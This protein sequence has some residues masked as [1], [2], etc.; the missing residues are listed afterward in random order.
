MKIL[1]LQYQQNTKLNSKSPST[2]IIFKRNN[3]YNNRTAAINPIAIT[4]VSFVG[5]QNKIQ[6]INDI[7]KKLS[8]KCEQDK[9]SELFI[10]SH[11]CMPETNS[12]VNN[13]I[14]DEEIE[15]L[16]NNVKIINGNADFS[17]T[18]LTNLGKLQEIKGN[19][20]FTNSKISDTGDLKYIG[21]SAYF[22]NCPIKDLKNIE[23]IGGNADFRFSNIIDLGKLKRI[24]RSAFFSHSPIKDLKDL[25]FIGGRADFSYS[26]VTSIK[27]TKINGYA[28]FNFSKIPY[29]EAVKVK[30]IYDI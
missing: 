12:K 27:N 2:N 10:I 21:Q 23:Y 11:F 14:T 29:T 20:I 17:K 28:N 18:S 30:T 25:E 3:I 5:N 6:R 7:C 19:A 24:G 13:P 8:I 4:S 9:E 15:L 1:P 16:F 22:R 26:L